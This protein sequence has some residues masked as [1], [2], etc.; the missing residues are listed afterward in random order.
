M[1]KIV[2]KFIIDHELYFILGLTPA[3]LACQYPFESACGLVLTP[4]RP[5]TSLSITLKR[6]IEKRAPDSS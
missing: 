3:L 1:S 2:R 4:P 5:T 6:Y